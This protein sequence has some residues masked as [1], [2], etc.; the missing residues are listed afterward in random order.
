MRLVDRRQRRSIPTGDAG[1]RSGDE[2][3]R[4]RRVELRA[5][6]PPQF[7]HQRLPRQAFAVRAA[8]DVS[9]RTMMRPASGRCA[10]TMP[11]G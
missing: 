7:C 11:W 5:A 1:E 3:V 10:P 2:E 9:A 8:E 4:E 6:A